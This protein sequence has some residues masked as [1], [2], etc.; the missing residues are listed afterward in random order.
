MIYLELFWSFFQV[1]L[2]TFGGGLAMLPLIESEMARHGWMAAEE[3]IN[4]V[5]VSESTPGPFAINIS[6]YV[7]MEAGGLFG[8][9]CATLGVVLPSFVIIL[10]V[11]GCLEKFRSS[12]WVQGGLSG[13]KPAVV[14]L[15]AASAISI[16]GA[17]FFPEGLALSAFASPSFWTACAIFAV[18]AVLIR[19]KVHPVF[20]IC[21]SALLGIA[22]GYLIPGM[23]AVLR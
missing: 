11:A 4:F 3:L 13:L 16:G 21:V 12:K 10:I 2:F 20:V 8:A 19:C 5:A 7:G 1:G 15:I 14:G 17:V 6:T 9:F 18:S 23:G 22:A